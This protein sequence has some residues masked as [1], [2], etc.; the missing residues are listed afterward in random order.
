M[1]FYYF[2]L[3]FI[4][5]FSVLKLHCRF[6]QPSFRFKKKTI[7]IGKKHASSFS[8]FS[9]P[10]FRSFC[11]SGVPFVTSACSGSCPKFTKGA[12]VV[13]FVFFL[14][15]T[16][17]PWFASFVKQFYHVWQKL[18]SKRRTRPI[19]NPQG[20]NIWIS[21]RNT[22]GPHLVGKNHHPFQMDV[23]P[24]DLI[25]NIHIYMVFFFHVH[26]IYSF[27]SYDNICHF[28]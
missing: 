5:I 28:L 17:G 19:K 8:F 10:I 27:L 1:Y 4:V 25:K 15:S 3:L 22:M 20:F 21:L 26:V 13:F 14:L 12:L 9:F 7:A 2:L 23:V 6:I 11:L 18:L 24:L 16:Y